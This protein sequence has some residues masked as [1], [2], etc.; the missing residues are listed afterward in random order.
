MKKRNIC[1]LEDSHFIETTL[2]AS[3]NHGVLYFNELLLLTVV[4]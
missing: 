1:I 4:F 2:H 3:D